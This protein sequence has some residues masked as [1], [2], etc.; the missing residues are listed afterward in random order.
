MTGSGRADRFVIACSSISKRSSRRPNAQHHAGERSRKGLFQGGR[1]AS[2]REQTGKRRHDEDPAQHADL[3]QTA[4]HGH[5]AFTQPLLAPVSPPAGLQR[6]ADRLPFWVAVRA[7]PEL[8]RI[9][10][11]PQPADHAADGINCRRTVSTC[12]RCVPRPRRS[13]SGPA[14]RHPAWQAC[15]PPP[16]RGWQCDGWMRSATVMT[17]PRT[18]QNRSVSSL[19]QLT[20]EIASAVRNDAW[21]DRTPKAAARILGA[22]RIDLLIHHHRK[23]V[24]ILSLIS[25]LPAS[26]V[27][28]AFG[29]CFFLARLLQRADHV[30]RAFR[31]VVRLSVKNGA[32]AGRACLQ[33]RRWRPVCR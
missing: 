26:K 6:P 33:A 9:C 15:P 29:R 2:G 21:P 31:P 30:E 17:P 28:D 5:I 7:S 25:A 13:G 14:P 18:A 24:T 20:M 3:R 10:A 19:R 1:R 27:S 11:G 8:T 23:G 16:P 22:Q 12:S 4:A 32:A